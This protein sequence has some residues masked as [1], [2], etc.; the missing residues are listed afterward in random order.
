MTLWLYWK[1][2]LKTLKTFKINKMKNAYKEKTLIYIDSKLK[3]Q[4]LLFVFEEYGNKAA[5]SEYIET[6]IRNDL[7]LVEKRMQELILS[8]ICD[9]WGKEIVDK[10]RLDIFKNSNG[11]I[12]NYIQS[13]LVNE[14]SKLLHE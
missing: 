4:V 2:K 6:L 13:V 11:D 8:R 3:E 7:R 1:N 9:D 5:L 14:K 10:I 12:Y